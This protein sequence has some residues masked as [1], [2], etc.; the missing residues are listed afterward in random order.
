MTSFDYTKY[1]Y[2]ELI[3]EASRLVS[4]QS[5]WTDAYNSSTAQVLIQTVAAITDQ[6]HY[7]LERRTKENFLSTAEL[8]SSVRA[9]VG[10][11]GYRPQRK[12]SSAGK[13]E[14]TLVDGSGIPVQ[15]IG[16]IT[17]PKYSSISYD[18][19][20]FVTKDEVIL[21]N[22]TTYPFEIDVVEGVQKT[23]TFDSSDVNGT[24]F[25]DQYV[26]MTDYTSVEEYSLY[27]TTPTQTFSDVQISTTLQP[28][29]G[30][31]GFANADDE[32]FDIRVTNTGMQIL[33][34]DG[35]N[36]EKPVGIVT[37]Q[38]I[39]SS[40]VDIEVISL[41]N[42]FVLD[43]Y[44]NLTD[45][46]SNV[47]SY[48]IENTSSIAGGKD[49][50]TTEEVKTNAPLLLN[51]SNRTVTRDDFK[52]WIEQSNIGAIV[53]TN[54]YGEEELGITTINA[55]NVYVTYLQS[56]GNT[57][58][59][60]EKTDLLDYLE[61]YKQITTNI[62]LEQAETIPVQVN[63]T[64]KRGQSLTAAHSEVYDYVRDAL[65]TF[66]QYQTN[67]LAN[68]LYH[69]EMVDQFHDLTITKA[70]TDRLIADYVN[71]ELYPMKSVTVPSVNSTDTDVTVIY[72]T[73]GDVYT[74]TV[75]GI[76]YSYTSVVSDTAD[77]VA[78]YLADYIS[79]DL[80]VTAT[81]SGNVITVT[82]EI[83]DAENL[84]EHSEDFD[85]AGWDQIAGDKPTV[86]AN[87][88]VA[89]NGT[90][91]ASTL[92]DASATVTQKM[93]EV[94]TISANNE[95]YIAS[96][97]V[98]KDA[99]TARY[100]AIQL[101]YTGG[102]SRQTTVHL[103]TQTGATTV[104]S[105]DTP[106]INVVSMTDYWKLE[107]G[108]PN[109]S[110][111]TSLT[112]SIYPAHDS[113]WGNT[114][115][116]ATTGSIIA[117]G[118]QLTKTETEIGSYVKTD[119]ESFSLDYGSFPYENRFKFA[120]NFLNAVW[121][122]TDVTPV[123]NLTDPDGTIHGT[124]I[125]G[126]NTNAYPSAKQ[127]ITSTKKGALSYSVSFDVLELTQ[128]SFAVEISNTTDLQRYNLSFNWSGGV[129]VV[130]A[131]NYDEG[132]DS[133]YTITAEAN[134]WYRVTLHTTFNTDL[135]DIIS[136][137]YYLSWNGAVATTM[138]LFGGYLQCDNT[139]EDVYV[140][141]LDMPIYYYNRGYTIT[142]ENSDI[143]ANA[144][145]N[146][147]IQLPDYLLDND[148]SQQIIYP[149]SVE[150]IRKS[151][152]SILAT[153]NATIVMVGNPDLTF[154]D[155]NPDTITRSAGS[156]ITDGFVVGM[157]IVIDGSSLND[158]TYK[159]ASLTAT[160][161]TLEAVNTLV[162]E[163]SV[164]DVTV[165]GITIGLI[166]G[167]TINYSTGLMTIPVPVSDDYVIRFLQNK[168]QNILCNEKQ[169]LYYYPAKTSYTTVTEELSTIVIT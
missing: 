102:T 138:G 165:T 44:A 133:S 59:D 6:L 93:Q 17:I 100:P 69:S 135:A 35:L 126:G 98:L 119:G 61:T 13:V 18:N 148:G 34:G 155:A 23:L 115:A 33:F 80:S 169:A 105:G 144:S 64:L 37:I 158:G 7:M 134:S 82:R 81:A 49:E 8:E 116:A 53:D 19:K 111:N 94:L 121:T 67:S 143:P 56:T 10:L 150:F 146:E 163:V 156:W 22:T 147:D 151:D 31:I 161:I 152:K 136:G 107:V 24:L 157:D 162:A 86:T 3:A 83:Y 131:T 137:N 40:G 70:G 73:D 30:S 109:N 2:D 92:N 154:A 48:I 90:T 20:F 76:N 130:A 21:T 132:I 120:E 14:I 112:Y 160:V 28:P 106:V 41:G 27:I 45:S 114:G 32:V 79:F 75:N 89:P 66:L 123:V 63:L 39:E 128:S 72:G 110:T 85:G 47:Y 29:I 12:I 46:G 96:L 145:I 78:N 95:N 38:W 164:S 125:T 58:T 88:T 9:I 26:E 122:K 140:K 166:Y 55:N 52:Y 97:F 25:T 141:T 101:E 129:P 104:A 50:E 77:D 103:N 65:T 149:T 71:L 11:L 15:S 108:L 142:N 1:D 113:V 62:V 153:D 74:A 4:T 42:T 117:W 68:N 5:E 167:G 57:L 139:S 16:T 51:T 118:A 36:G 99:I 54:V 127:T 159:I 84:A 43:N 91:T 124:T 87:S 168:D 60:S